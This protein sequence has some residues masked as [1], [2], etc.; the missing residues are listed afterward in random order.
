MA[1]PYLSDAELT[2]LKELGFRN[3]HALDLEILGVA[4]KVLP[5][6]RVIV[7]RGALSSRF[8]ERTPQSW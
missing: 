1:A 5:L 4:V 2:F 3:A 7:S 8:G 6:E